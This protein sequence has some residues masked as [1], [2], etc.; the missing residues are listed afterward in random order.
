MDIRQLSSLEHLHVC[1]RIAQRRVEFLRGLSRSSRS[2]YPT[3]SK[4]LL[5]MA[6]VEDL[7]VQAIARFA[8]Q[9]DP[10]SSW[11]LNETG[12]RQI[13]R[14]HVDAFG[15]PALPGG[16]DA[17]GILARVG[18]VDYQAARFFRLLADLTQDPACRNFFDIMSDEDTESLERASAAG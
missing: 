6:D 2:A 11:Q 3:L 17:A 14:E 10:P 13:I 5:E 9:I 1:R 12:L 8:E 18:R 15:L 7:H 4:M 16:S